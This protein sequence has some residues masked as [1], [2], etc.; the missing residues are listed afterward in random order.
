[1]SERELKHKRLATCM[2]PN[3]FSIAATK[4]D[5]VCRMRQPQTQIHILHTSAYVS[6]RQHMVSIRLLPKEMPGAA[7]SSR[8]YTSCT[9]TEPS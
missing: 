7:C 3:V 2:I 9:K 1:L 8:R 6:I 5:A 4:R